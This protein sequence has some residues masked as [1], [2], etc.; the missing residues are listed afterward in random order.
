MK[1]VFFPSIR[2]E[3]RQYI[4]VLKTFDKTVKFGGKELD[5]PRMKGYNY[6]V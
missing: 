2:Q 6:V 4:T 5:N 3:K 1:T